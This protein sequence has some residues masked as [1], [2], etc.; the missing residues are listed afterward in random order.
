MW[1]IIKALVI[2]GICVASAP[3]SALALSVSPISADIH[4]YPGQEGFVPIVLTSDTD[5]EIAIELFSVLIEENDSIT[6]LPLTE[7]MKTRYAISESKITIVQ[8]EEKIIEVQ[9]T[10]PAEGEGKD[11]VAVIM[12]ESL[13]DENQ[14]YVK[15][16]LSTMVFI[17]YGEQPQV[18]ARY[19]QTNYSRTWLSSLPL[20]IFVTA[21][22]EGNAIARPR[23]EVHVKNMLGRRL[24][25]IF[26]ENTRTSIA[27]GSE[28]Q[29]IFTWG[30]SKYETGFFAPILHEISQFAIG[31]F[32]VE[33]HFIPVIGAEPDI[34][35]KRI[36][37]FPWRLFVMFTIASTGI[38]AIMKL[39]QRYLHASR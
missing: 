22:N 35:R 7:D 15:E 8:G 1:G 39:L 33:T 5:T 4:V 37:I 9:V 36:I 19:L 28:Q 34:T 38:L 14:V 13:N 30:E 31:I 10:T 11:A 12:S 23:V 3:A 27:A 26:P 18:G 17:S 16:A 32:T 21:Q 2:A 24:A 25:T 29:Y 20:Q 6:L